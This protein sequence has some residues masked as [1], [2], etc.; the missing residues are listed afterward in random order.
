MEVYNISN[1]HPIYSFTWF[2]KAILDEENSI[3]CILDLL[4]FNDC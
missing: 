1:V 2:R 3:N 4:P